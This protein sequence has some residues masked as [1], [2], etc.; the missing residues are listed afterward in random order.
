MPKGTKALCE[1]GATLNSCRDCIEVLEAEALD[2]FAKEGGAITK[3]SPHRA[4]GFPSHT[5]SNAGKNS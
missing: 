5:R 1:C 4:S 2:R 3:A